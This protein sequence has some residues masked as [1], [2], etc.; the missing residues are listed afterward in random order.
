[1]SGSGADATNTTFTQRWAISGLVVGIA[2]VAG[3][4]AAG[5]PVLE[6]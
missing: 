3:L 1:M 2:C 6:R 5:A 4:W